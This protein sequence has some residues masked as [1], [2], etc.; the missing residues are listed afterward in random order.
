MRKKL[1]MV[2]LGLI[3]ILVALWGVLSFW[4]RPVPDHPFFSHDG[5]LVMAHRGSGGLWPENT[6]YAFEHAVALGVDVLEMDVQST[7]DGELVVIHD[8]TV[9]R[10]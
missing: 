4:A 1:V 2:L 7:K 5:V 3:A 9:D 6:L 10:Q 8:S